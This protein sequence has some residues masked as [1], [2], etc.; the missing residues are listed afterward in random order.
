MASDKIRIRVGEKV[1]HTTRSTITS[2]G[3]NTYLAAMVDSIWQTATVGSSSAETDMNELFID[4]NPAY[5]SVL[6]DLLRTGELDIP[7]EMSEKALFREALYYGL[8]DQVRAA[9]EPEPLDGHTL[10]HTTTIR[11][12]YH[13]PA[14]GP[15]DAYVV[16]APG[17]IRAG[18]DSDG[19][20]CVARGCLVRVYDWMLEQQAILSLNLEPFTD[21][22]IVPGAGGTK[23]L[24][25]TG[26]SGDLVC[27]DVCSG[28]V[29][30]EYEPH[31]RENYW[32][33]AITMGGGDGGDCALAHCTTAY[34]PNLPL[35]AAPD[36]VGAWDFNTGKQVVQVDVT[37]GD[38]S[39]TGSQ[40]SSCSKLQWLPEKKLLHV[41]FF[42]QSDSNSKTSFRL[43]DLR[44]KSVSRGGDDYVA[45]NDPTYKKITDTV[46]MED[47]WTLWAVSD[48]LWGLPN[49]P[50]YGAPPALPHLPLGFADLRVGWGIQWYATPHIN[51]CHKY[52]SYLPRLACHRSQLFLSTGCNVEVYS[53]QCPDREMGKFINAGVL[54]SGSG[55]EIAGIS[56]GGD[57]VF[58]LHGF[59]DSF[60]VWETPA[61]SRRCIKKPMDLQSKPCVL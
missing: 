6:L 42:P 4:R 21:A 58:M 52:P 53:W 35:A 11:G 3:R 44:E 19:G 61:R 45:W 27:F 54:Q 39:Q 38:S 59:E 32:P 46:V 33:V 51:P 17:S 28:D 22:T 9:A 55:K 25:T 1:F 10:R 12:H 36:I 56:I 57:R 60:E 48:P 18:P 24:A 40:G 43:V 7:P 8:E 20:C 29:V 5:F 14:S 49:P 16:G 30:H 37:T 2:G 13:P 23:V 34:V 15:H 31:D 41:T 47:S 26:I 50:V